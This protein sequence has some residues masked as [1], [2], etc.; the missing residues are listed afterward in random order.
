[1]TYSNPQRRV[2][3]HFKAER[4]KLKNTRGHGDLPRTKPYLRQVHPKTQVSP[5]QRAPDWRPWAQKSSL[6]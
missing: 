2:F 5:K 4:Q 1:M 3:P 6:K